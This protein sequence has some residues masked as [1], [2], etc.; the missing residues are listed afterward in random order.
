VWF[1][2]LVGGVIG[3]ALFISRQPIEGTVTYWR[4]GQW[5]DLPI[6]WYGLRSFVLQMGLVLVFAHGVLPFV[7]YHLVRHG[8]GIIPIFGWLVAAMTVLSAIYMS[9]VRRRYRKAMFHKAS[10]TRETM[11]VHAWWTGKADLAYRATCLIGG[12]VMLAI[13]TLPS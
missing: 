11:S 2:F 6:M 5:Y 4:Q 9:L 1:L 7:A 8:D 13:A 12:C 3:L 10:R